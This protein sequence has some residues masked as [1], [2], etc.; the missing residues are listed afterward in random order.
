MTRISQEHVSQ[1]AGKPSTF[2][3]ALTDNGVREVTAVLDS[4]ARLL[5]RDQ[6]PQP[7][8]VESFGA[9]NAALNEAW[10]AVTTALRGDPTAAERVAETD[11]LVDLLSDIRRVDA[12]VRTADTGRRRAALNTVRTALDRFHHVDSAAELMEMAPEAVCAL[13]FDRSIISRIHDSIW[14]PEAVH[15][16]GDPGWTEEILRAGAEHPTRI[17]PHLREAEIVRRRV[18]ILVTDVQHQ[19]HK[20]HKEIAETSLSRSYVGAPLTTGSRV[21]G[22]VHADRYFHRGDV[23]GFDLELLSLFAEG[24]SYALQRAVMVERMRSMRATIDKLA[25][26]ISSTVYRF[27]NREILL[28]RDDESAE[29]T[30]P[31]SPPATDSSYAAY[32]LAPESPLTRR[33]LDVLRWMATGDT[34]GRIADRLVVSEGTVKTHVKNILRKLGAANRAD[35]VARWLN[36]ERKAAEGRFRSAPVHRQGGPP[37][38][39]R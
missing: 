30:A 33:E 23:D 19:A 39:S 3:M 37:P 18:G 13:G 38:Q 8:E 6:V 7:A 35:A 15:V 28:S 29:P 26:G 2:R 16:I 25:E 36:L 22:F 5:D 10:T 31:T 20:V 21:I 12:L 4:A 9:A 1:R 11:D 34:N 32:E 27:A 14:V 24:A 17:G